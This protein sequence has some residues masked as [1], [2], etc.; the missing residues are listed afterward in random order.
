MRLK[1]KAGISTYWWG[2]SQKAQLLW[3]IG[4]IVSHWASASF[5]LHDV[6]L[7]CCPFLHHRPVTSLSG[8]ADAEIKVPSGENTE[9]KCSPFIAW[10]SSVYSHMCYAY[11]QGFLPCL[12]LPFRSIHLHFFQNLSRFFP[13]LALANTGSCV[14]LQNEIGQPASCRFPCWVP[15]EYK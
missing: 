4:G 1:S 15:A 14:G 6:A 8:A 3:A 11:C 10:S 2:W 13:V 7:C 9:L 12:F 5:C